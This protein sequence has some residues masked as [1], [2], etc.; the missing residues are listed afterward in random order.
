MTLDPDGARAIDHHLVHG[1]ILD[2]LLE[3][4]KPD[5]TREHA[6][7]EQLV[8]IAVEGRSLLAHERRHAIS[9][10]SMLGLLDVRGVVHEAP[11][12]SAGQVVDRA[13]RPNP[14][15]G[16]PTAPNL[17]RSPAGLGTS[18]SSRAKL[19]AAVSSTAWRSDTRSVALAFTASELAPLPENET[20]STS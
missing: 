6:L 15:A 8:L 7:D 20:S 4:T 18:R 16:M 1:R 9:K 11:A 2:Q 12:E 14:A 13:H 19:C 17:R 5:C 10:R 3:R